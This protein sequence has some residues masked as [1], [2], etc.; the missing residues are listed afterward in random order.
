MIVDGF[1]NL[2]RAQ[3]AF[4]WIRVPENFSGFVFLQALKAVEGELGPACV[5]GFNERIHRVHV[6]NVP[7]PTPSDT[8]DFQG[9]LASRQ[10]RLL[11]F[12]P[13]SYN[14]IIITHVLSQPCFKQSRLPSMRPLKRRYPDPVECA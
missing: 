14:S 2:I 3:A 1:Q 4:D 13:Y 10:R 7:L 9:L 11:P 5:K 6:I 8:E 12:C